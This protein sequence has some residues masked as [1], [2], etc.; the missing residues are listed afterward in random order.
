MVDAAI[1]FY[2][3]SSNESVRSPPSQV[4]LFGDISTV[5]PSNS[6]VALETST[7]TLIISSA[8]PVV[9]IT[10]I[11]S[12]TRLCGLDPYMTTIAHWRSKVASHSSSS[13]KVV[14][15]RLD[16]PPMRAPRSSEAFLLWC[17]AP[18]ST[19]Y[20][21]KTLESSLGDSLERPRHSS[22]LSARPSCKRCRSPTNS[23][24]S[25]TP[26]MG[27]L[28]PT[29]TDLLP[30][31]KRYKDSYS[32]KTSMEEDTEIDTIETEDG[33]E[34]AIVD[35]DVVRDQIVKPVGGDSSSLSRTKDDTVRLVEDMPVDLDASIRDFYHYMSEEI[36]MIRVEMEMEIKEMIMD[37]VEMEIG[38][39]EMVMDRVEIGMEMEE[40]KNN[41]MATYT[42]RFQEITMMC[43]KM[44]PEEEDRRSKGDLT[45]TIET[46]VDSNHQLN[47]RILEV[48]MLLE[49]RRLVVMR[50][51]FM[52]VHCL[53]AIGVSCITKDSVQLS[54]IT[55][56]GLDIWQGI[57]SLLWLNKARV[58]KARGKAYVLGGGDANP[59]SNTVTDL[60]SFDVIISMDWLAKNHAVIVCDEK[61]VRIPYENEILIV[62]GDKS[63]EKR[64]M[65][66]ILSCVKAHKYIEKGCQL[67]LKQVTV[68]ENKDKSEEKQLKDVPI[69]R[70]FLKVFLEDLP[71]LSPIRQVEFQINLVPG[72]TPITR[73][74]YRLAHLEMQSTQLRELSNKGF[75]RLSF[76]PW[77]AL[78][79]FF[80]QKDGSLRMCIDYRKLNK[81]TIKNRYPLPRVD[82][83]FD[84]LQG[85]SVYLKINLS[86][87][88]YVD[89][90][91]IE[92]IK[93][94]ESPKTLME[95]CQFLGLA[96]YYR[97]FI[98][99]SENFMVYCDEFYKGLGAVLM[100]REKVIAYTSWQLKIQEK[101]YTMHDLELRV[102]V[103]AL[104]MWR[105]YLYG[106]RWLELLSDYDCKIHYH[107]G[108]GNVV[109][110]ALS[111][112]ADIATYVGKCMTCAKFKAGYMKPS[113]LLVQPKI[114]SMEIGEHND[115]LRDQAT[116]DN[117]WPEW[118]RH[119]TIVH[120]TK[121]LHTADYTQLYDC[122]KYNQ[123]EVDELKAERLA[124]SQD[125][126]ALIANSNNPYA[127]SA[128]HQDQSSFNQNYLQQPMPNPED[129]TDSTTAMNMALALMAKEFKLNYS[130]P[131]NNNRRISSNPRNRQIAQPGNLNRYNAVQNVENQGAQNLRVQNVRNQNGL[132]GVQGNGNQNQIGNGNLVAVRAERNAAGHN[133]NQ[134]RC[135]NCRGVGHFARDCTVRP[136]RKD[137]AYLQTQLLIAQKEEA[138]I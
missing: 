46:T 67:F 138:G 41:D 37:R 117:N 7:T 16:Y 1:I 23:V 73:A 107:T 36:V 104:K 137:A 131:T 6:M 4:I 115:G 96:D 87:G 88:I 56:R 47:E 29:R 74:P 19:F 108:K 45:P 116:K 14:S 30:P 55:V 99:G 3:D 35:G 59:G 85:S 68:K 114:S 44:V 24:P 97:Q 102:V 22:L 63:D 54:V 130:T 93:D 18:L 133:G 10:L 57:A 50:R 49:P 121:D 91:K 78:V 86:K 62:Q 27:S 80:K 17:V 69:V 12:P 43:T 75:I 28:A 58:P 52:E 2:S 123:K 81:L 9:E 125:P 15:P 136:R 135:Y 71:E 8:A 25:S 118:S 134:I 65:L 40:V 61:I 132:I 64:S 95:I 48:K 83:L 100:Q 112:K 122:M 5:I 70:D 66:R 128:T 39:E 13:S 90:T 127:V 26:V 20:P 84:Q 32:P 124:K 98:K 89:Q 106:R 105:H 21:P 31:R 38:M 33:K 76:S 34:M 92:S 103:F 42:Q 60:G 11:A 53:T 77:G 51:R 126:L 94:W 79:L 109:A 113:G 111:Q 120:Q 110:D 82:D 119:V 129:I 101:N 72:A